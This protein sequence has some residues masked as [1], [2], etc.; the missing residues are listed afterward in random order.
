M[1][2]GAAEEPEESKTDK[3]KEPVKLS[4]SA[5]MLGVV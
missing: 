5:M 4:K 1:N 3:P 2:K